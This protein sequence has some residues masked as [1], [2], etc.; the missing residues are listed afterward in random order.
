MAAIDI[1]EKLPPADTI[2]AMTVLGD[3][4]GAGAALTAGAKSYRCWLTTKPCYVVKVEL[5][6][7]TGTAAGTA[8]AGYSTSFTAALT[9]SGFGDS[10]VNLAASTNID[11]PI[12]QVSG[13]TKPLLLAPNTWVGFATNASAVATNTILGVRIT[14][15]LA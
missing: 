8:Q 14:Y 7:G 4:A 13:D 3:G 15:R 5:L 6:T 12:A 10:A 2:I 9:T 1:T 11:L